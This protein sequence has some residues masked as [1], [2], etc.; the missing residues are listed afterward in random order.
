ML[1]PFDA[2]HTLLNKVTPI[3]K[4]ETLPLESLLNRVLYR[5][6]KAPFSMPYFDNSAMDGYGIKL[7]DRGKSVHCVHKSMAGDESR[8][9]GEGECIKIMTGAKVDSSIEA[10]VPIENIL[11]E[12]EE[13]CIPDEVKERANI[14]LKGEEFKEN[15]VLIPSGEILDA[16][17]LALLAALGITHATVFLKPL[18]H[19]IPTGSEVSAHYEKQS[20]TG[21]FDS[22]SHY[23]RHNPLSR[24][25]VLEVVG[26]DLEKLKESIDLSADLIITTGGVSKGDADLTPQAF[27]EEGYERIFSHIAIKPGK[28]FSFCIKE[29][30]AVLLTG[31]PLAAVFNYNLF[32][33]PMIRK[34]AGVRA[35]YPS[36]KKALLLEDIKRKAGRGEVIPGVFDKEGFSPLKKRGSGM[37]SVTAHS[38]AV[39]LLDKGTWVLEKGSIVNV[40]TFEDFSETF[41]D[42]ITSS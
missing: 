21:V 30:L 26:D 42:F 29:K 22:S 9:I 17:K 25:N 33:I 13:I 11:F 2:L 8:G 40:I 14:R 41:E 20:K 6:I 37:I 24:M 7:S 18:I 1:S 32:V 19:I 38:N 27:E 16:G 28:P 12:G 34:L 4:S 35:Y 5:E 39:I 36:F 15:E 3:Q 31:N 10:V 23:F